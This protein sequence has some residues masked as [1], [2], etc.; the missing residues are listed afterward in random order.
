MGRTSFASGKSGVTSASLVLVFKAHCIVFVRSFL[1]R[2][3]VVQRFSQQFPA[4]ARFLIFQGTASKLHF[5]QG[6]SLQEWE[7]SWSCFCLFARGRAPRRIITQFPFQFHSRGDRSVTDTLLDRAFCFLDHFLLYWRIPPTKFGTLHLRRSSSP[8]HSTSF[9]S[10]W[11]ERFERH[12]LLDLGRS[13]REEEEAKNHTVDST[14]I[15]SLLPAFFIPPDCVP[16]HSS[17]FPLC[18]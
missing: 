1:T 5:Q 16:P 9:Y 3:S 11:I 2:H 14:N 10:T 18:L 12:P 13:A 4:F 8:Y 6:F 15:F 17:L 7:L